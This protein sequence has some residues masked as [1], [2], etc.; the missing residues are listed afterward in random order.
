MRKDT[1][2]SR[3]AMATAAELRVLLGQLRRR[4]RD[5][6]STGDF[7]PSQLSA[8]R[9]LEREG[10]TTV[11]LLARAE[12]VRPQSMGATVSALQAAGFISTAPH[13]TDR[14]QTLL[15][16]TPACQA[17]IKAHR[18]ARE[19]WLS[20]SIQRHLSPAEQKQLADAVKLLKRLAEPPA[21][22]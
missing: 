21:A 22:S 12:G 1:P 16:L 15:A 6:A 9:R 8:L 20:H 18:A 3:Q 17:W 13:P 11:T 2:P 5:E 10:P 4:L 7:S 19:D 14:R